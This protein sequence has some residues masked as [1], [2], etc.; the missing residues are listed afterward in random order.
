MDEPIQSQPEPRP[1]I[2]E[3]IAG[4]VQNQID[5]QQAVNL[6]IAEQAPAFSKRDGKS[7][8]GKI[9]AARIQ[10]AVSE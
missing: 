7:S 1:R 8:W 4:E 9:I 3:V 2:G 5:D 6:A 10:K